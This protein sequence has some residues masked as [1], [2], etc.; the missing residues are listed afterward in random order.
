VTAPVKD[1]ADA[2]IVRALAVTDADLFFLPEDVIATK[3]PA[4][5][6]EGIRSPRDGVCATLRWADSS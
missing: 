1:R 3:E 5:P 6:Q 4:A 2:A